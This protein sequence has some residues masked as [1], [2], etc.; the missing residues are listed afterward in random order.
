MLKMDQGRC[1][2]RRKGCM[3]ILHWKMELLWKLDLLWRPDRRYT[4][5]EEATTATMISTQDFLRRRI[6]RAPSSHTDMPLLP[7]YLGHLT[8]SR[9]ASLRQLRLISYLTLLRVITSRPKPPRIS[10]SPIHCSLMR[11][12]HRSKRKRSTFSSPSFLPMVI[13][14]HITQWALHHRR[15]LP[16]EPH[17]TRPIHSSLPLLYPLVAGLTTSPSPKCPPASSSSTHS[18]FPPTPY[19]PPPPHLPQAHPRQ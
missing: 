6:K 16:L 12:Y 14:T 19:P 3:W 4:T 10:S 2:R 13:P 5:M 7:M 1:Y 15:T 18:C 9:L 11:H 8:P 17:L